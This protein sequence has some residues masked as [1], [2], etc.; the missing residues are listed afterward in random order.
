MSLERKEAGQ[1]PFLFPNR[2]VNTYQLASYLAIAIVQ[3]VVMIL[4]QRGAKIHRLASL[5]KIIR[6]TGKHWLADLFLNAF[7]DLIISLVPTVDDD[8]GTIGFDAEALECHQPAFQ[9]P[10]RGDVR[11]R[12][13]Q[14]EACHAQDRVP[15][16]GKLRSHVHEDGVKRVLGDIYDAIQCGHVDALPLLGLRNATEQFEFGLVGREQAGKKMAVQAVQILKR[17][18]ESQAMMKVEQEVRIAQGAS[19]VEQHGPFAG[20]RGQLNTEI[21]GDGGCADSSLC[22]H[23]YDQLIVGNEFS[24]F[25]ME[26]FF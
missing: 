15:L 22:A 17:I 26:I 19:E 23:D 20:R 7:E 9:R 5:A 3:D 10:Q 24:F 12:H 1:R 8:P 14:N 21:H 13:N 2:S 11:L 16:R 25:A 4:L 18:P 6:E